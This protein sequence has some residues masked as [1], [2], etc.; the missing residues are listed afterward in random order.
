MKQILSIILTCSLLATAFP[1]ILGMC[2]HQSIETSPSSLAAEQHNSSTT[3]T[4]FDTKTNTLVKSELE[5]YLVGV[6]AAEMPASYEEEALKAQAVA[7]RSYILSKLS[8]ENPDHPQATVCTNAA[9]CKGYLAENDAKQ[10]W[11]ERDRNNY[12]QK[13]ESAV[14]STKGV[15]MICEEAV[16]E[17]FF[18]SSGGGR[19][20]NSEDVWQ[21]SRPYLRSVESPDPPENNTSTAVF[22]KEEFFAL[23]NPHL[24]TRLSSSSAVAV[25]DIRLTDGGSVATITLCGKEFK[26]TEIRSIFNLKSANFTLV[27]DNNKVIFNVTGHGHGVGMSQKGANQMAKDG[28]KYTEILSHYYTNI[29]IVKL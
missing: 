26:G 27:S 23:L 19:T 25:S 10:K 9:H 1:V 29:Q 2:L 8:K 5:E 21:E 12:W 24:R 6:L 15:Y 22:T 13:L 16:V 17:A 14:S 18:F 3:I 4:F 11:S 28:K 20:E 7:A